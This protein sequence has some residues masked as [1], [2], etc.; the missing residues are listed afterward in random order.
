MHSVSSRLDS[1]T[2]ADIPIVEKPSPVPAAKPAPAPRPVRSAKVVKHLT[3][4][5]ALASQAR[6][7]AIELCLDGSAL[8]ATALQT[9][10]KM[11]ARRA[12]EHMKI[13]C[14]VGVIQRQSG[15][16]KRETVYVINPGFVSKAENGTAIFDFG[17]GQLY[18][19][20]VRLSE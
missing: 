15:P 18:F 14:K 1:F 11:S 17:S 20:R 8:T 10:M 12:S 13:L 4:M 7:T 6:L 5:K 9:P 16:D 19:P 3:M 2:A